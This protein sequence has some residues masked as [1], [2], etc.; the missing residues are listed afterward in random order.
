MANFEGARM[1]TGRKTKKASSRKRAPLPAS[2][3][4]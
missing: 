3:A 4:K 1:M 2:A